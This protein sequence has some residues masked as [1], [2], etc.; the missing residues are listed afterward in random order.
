MKKKPISP[1]QS[2]LFLIGILVVLS[3]LGLLFVFEAS[4]SEAYRTFGD[5]YHFLKHHAIGLAI[6]LV[7]FSMAALV[8][9]DLWLKAAP[10]LYAGGIL[11]LLLVF[12]PG[13]GL[14]LNGARRWISFG[15]AVFQPVELMKLALIAYLSSW[16]SKYQKLPQF[17]VL[18]GIPTLLVLL[19]PDLGSMMVLCAIGFS[20]YF[21]AGGQLKQFML[22]IGGAA[23]MVLLAILASPYRR[24]RLLTFLNPT[25]D[26]TGSSFHVRQLTIALGRGGLFGQGIGNS[27][28]KYAYL[29]EA[30]TDSI[31][32]IV[33]EEI[34][35]VGSTIIITLFLTFLILLFRNVIKL[36][37]GSPQRLLGFGIFFWLAIQIILNLAAVVGLVP[38]TGIPLPFFSYGRSAQVMLLLASG[39][40]VSLGRRK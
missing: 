10:L 37:T 34:G 8:P 26:P 6:G 35:F 18:L 25:A 36:P 33:A 38:L 11:S 32:A 3:L 22:T 16:L 9:A 28:Q 24:E 17:L 1:Q 2:V 12:I 13:I 4:T 20:L 23:I 15:L 21:V 30:S 39:I 31:F 5:Q 27:S 40:I 7:F 14:N 29:P 19:Q